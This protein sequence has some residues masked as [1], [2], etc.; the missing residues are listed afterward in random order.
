MDVRLFTASPCFLGR[1]DAQ[2]LDKLASEGAVIR[3]RN[4]STALV[5]EGK[6]LDIVGYGIWSPRT[7]FLQGAKTI[8]Y[9]DA[10]WQPVIL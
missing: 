9:F 10:A 6:P 4:P 2:I 3:G 5:Q 7:L 8:R 1:S